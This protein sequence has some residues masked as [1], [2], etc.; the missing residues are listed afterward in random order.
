MRRPSIRLRE[1]RGAARS[2]PSSR[3]GRTRRR[4]HCS[5]R[6]LGLGRDH[7]ASASFQFPAKRENVSIFTRPALP[8]CFGGAGPG[9]AAQEHLRRVVAAGR[10]GIRRH[11]TVSAVVRNHHC[12]L[13]S[14]Q[15][16]HGFP[17]HVDCGACF[18]RVL[19]LENTDYQIGAAELFDLFHRGLRVQ[20]HLRPPPSAV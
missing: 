18:L 7:H 1:Y 20:L 16:G 12:P 11:R 8:W 10:L 19:R 4:T 9:Q 3:M 15:A 5:G 14:G 13:D 17:H 6:G 2:N